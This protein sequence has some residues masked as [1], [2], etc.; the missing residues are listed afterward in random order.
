MIIFLPMNKHSEIWR[1]TG[2]ALTSAQDEILTK[3]AEEARRVLGR[4]LDMGTERDQILSDRAA[5]AKRALETTH[6]IVR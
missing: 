4:T 3:R 2:E 6:G 1:G 5:Q